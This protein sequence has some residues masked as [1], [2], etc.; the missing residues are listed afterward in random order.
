[1]SLIGVALSALTANSKGG[2]LL[3]TIL[4]FPLMI[5]PVIF[6][7]RASLNVYNG[8]D[9]SNELLFLVGFFMLLLSTLPW[10]SAA[11]IKTRIH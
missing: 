11:A 6:G 8:L 2:T 5:P 7:T 9:S 4:V 1:M 10:A 3:L